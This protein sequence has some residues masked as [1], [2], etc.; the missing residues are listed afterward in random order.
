MLFRI[1]KD[2]VISDL[3]AQA[4][5]FVCGSETIEPTDTVEEI[6][7]TKQGNLEYQVIHDL[8]SWFKLENSGPGMSPEC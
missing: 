6:R 4:K 2:T 8:K 5:L 1:G 3:V 7:L